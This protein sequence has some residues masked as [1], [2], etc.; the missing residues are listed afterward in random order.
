MKTKPYKVYIVGDDTSFLSNVKE[1]MIDL[2]PS[3]GIHFDTTRDNSPF[4]SDGDIVLYSSKDKFPGKVHKDAKEARVP[5][6]FL[7]ADQSDTASFS[8]QEPVFFASVQSD[9][10]AVAEFL[11]LIMLFNRRMSIVEK[12]DDLMERIDLLDDVIV[13]FGTTLNNKLCTIIGYADFALSE[14]S[15]Q[16]M[17]KALQ[18]AL[19]AGLDT[20]Q[21]LQNMLLSVKAIVRKNKKK[22]WAA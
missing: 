17:Q 9:A 18:I 12:Q 20:A 5:M 8:I 3:E 13:D 19:E 22:K 10:H 15:I 1:E 14:A 6:V 11:T 7:E 2:L 21:L 4:I 16:E